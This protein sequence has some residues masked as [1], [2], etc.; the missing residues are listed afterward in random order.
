MINRN[1]LSVPRAVLERW[2]R[3]W[4]LRRRLPT[5]FGSRPIW[6]TPD[7]RLRFL[8]WGE[9][10]F[11][12]E[13]LGYVES[14]VKPGNTVWDIGANVGEFTIAAAHRAVNGRVLA[15]EADPVLAGLLQRSLNESRNSDLSVDLLCAAVADHGGIGRFRIAA[16][17]RAANALEGLEG[18]TQ[19]GGARLCAFV[20][21]VTLDDLLVQSGDPAV[22]KIDVEGAEMLVLQ[23][24]KALLTKVRPLLVVEVSS[25]N[26]T[27]VAA[28][29]QRADYAL[30]DAETSISAGEIDVCAFNT[31]AVPR[32]KLAVLFSSA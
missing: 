25:T 22:V 1:T 10:A 15:V 20:A 30:F 26:R 21:L 19:M 4:I 11:D 23:G 29:L 28:Q 24:G 14:F 7:A 5:R 17:G 31:L 12:Q 6:V 18:S 9:A 3:G 8:K 32:E 2:S 13:L 27:A 16:R